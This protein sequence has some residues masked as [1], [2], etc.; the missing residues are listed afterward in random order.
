[1]AASTV[2]RTALG[3]PVGGLNAL[4]GIYWLSAGVL[5]LTVTALGA[6]PDGERAWIALVGLFCSVL[7]GALLLPGIRE[8]SEGAHGALSA[9]GGLGIAAGTYLAG[10]THREL[11]GLLVVYVTG[12]AFVIAQRW[13]PI[14]LPGAAVLH[15]V[16][17]LA[18]DTPAAWA[19]WLAS[20]GIGSLAG[21]IAGASVQAQRHL[22]CEQSR[23][24]ERLREADASKTALLH[25][26]GHELSRP[27]TTMLGLSQTLADR[28]EDLG[29]DARRELAARVADGT[30]RLR[31]SLDELLGLTRLQEGRVELDLSRVALPDLVT[32]ALQRA[33]T[34][35]DAVEVGD[36][37]AVEVV[38]DRGRLAH[39]IANLVSNAERHGEG[40]AVRIDALVERDDVEVRVSDRGP[41]IDDA[42]KVAVFEP[43]V[44]A[45]GGD[46]TRGSGLGLSLV[47]EFVHLHGGSV[48]VEDRPGGGTVVVLRFPRVPPSGSAAPPTAGR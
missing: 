24:A 7:G 14:V 48:W 1:M 17:L 6:F 38:V 46:P 35:A 41:G 30:L 33:E 4:Q 23:L 20:W 13:V 12:F 8:L 19:V 18:V 2:P 16:V 42:D 37:P 15:L 43:F 11:V 9:L 21:W 10:P 44:R 40:I 27:M 45:R 25:A 29:P 22:A 5:V 31:D 39:A 26:V 3:I 47:R 36:V 34:E 32:L 28:G